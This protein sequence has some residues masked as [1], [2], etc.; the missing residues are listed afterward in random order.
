MGGALVAL[1]LGLLVGLG[2][3]VGV[4]GIGVPAQI[5]T[6]SNE[7]GFCVTEVEVPPPPQLNNIAAAK[8]ESTG[9]KTSH[10]RHHSIEH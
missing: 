2:D 6:D 9:T 8:K 4:A 5:A 7:D 3:G 1:A 10:L